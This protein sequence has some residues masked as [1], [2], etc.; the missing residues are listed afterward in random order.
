MEELAKLNHP[1]IMGYY[2]YEMKPEGLYCFLEF[3]SGGELKP[4]C[5]KKVS[6]IKALTLLNQ[7]L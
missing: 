5:K 1:N 7:L 3:C 2:G 4:Y 6:E